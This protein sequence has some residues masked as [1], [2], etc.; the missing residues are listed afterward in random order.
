MIRTYVHHDL[1]LPSIQF[2]GIIWQVFLDP[3]V[4]VIPSVFLDWALFVIPVLRVNQY[5]SFCVFLQIPE[6]LF[7]CVLVFVMGFHRESP[8]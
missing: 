3:K 2:W 7:Y 5:L 1:C 8:E 6:H 4:E